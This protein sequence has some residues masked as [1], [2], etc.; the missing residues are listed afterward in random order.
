M[1][2]TLEQ[3]QTIFANPQIVGYTTIDGKPENAAILGTWLSRVN[4]AS[5][6]T[7]LAIDVP[8]VEGDTIKYTWEFCLKDVF[9]PNKDNKF[10]VVGQWH[11]QPPDGNWA[12]FPSNSPPLAFYLGYRNNRTE[13]AFEYLNLS[14]TPLETMRVAVNVWYKMEITVHWSRTDGWARV[15]MGDNAAIIKSGPNMLNEYRHF[16]KLGQYRDT[17]LT[18]ENVI[19]FRNINMVKV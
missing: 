16:F 10:Y 15:Q 7:E 13:L 9:T 19:A 2:I 11:D 5:N 17:S 14:A 12:G 6:R 1:T 4:A 8:W 18:S 3:L